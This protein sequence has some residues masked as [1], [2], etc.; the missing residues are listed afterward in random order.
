MSYEGESVN[1]LQMEIQRQKIDI[2]TSKKHLFLD[3]SSTNIATIVPSLYQRVQTRSAE[4]FWLLSQS[5]PHLSF[6]LFV[7]SETFATQL[8]TALRDKHFPP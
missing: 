3:I 8:W 6:N 5:L 1:R 2:R 4:V 7:F